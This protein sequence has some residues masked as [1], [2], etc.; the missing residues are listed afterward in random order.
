MLINDYPKTSDNIFNDAGLHLLTKDIN[1][2]NNDIECDYLIIS[3]PSGIWL[4]DEEDITKFLENEKKSI[5][6]RLILLRNKTF[7]AKRNNQL[8]I[9][10]DTL[11][12]FTKVTLR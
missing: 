1:E 12:I 7:K 5:L 6:K 2:I 11:D 4:A 3:K 8:T 9:D 10:I